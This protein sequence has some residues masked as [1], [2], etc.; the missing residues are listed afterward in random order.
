MFLASLFL[1]AGDPFHAGYSGANFAMQFAAV[2]SFSLFT[3]FLAAQS[4]FNF[5][6]LNNSKCYT[7]VKK[8]A[9]TCTFLLGFMITSEVVFTF[10]SN[11][12]A[13]A[14]F[15][16]CSLLML[17]LFIIKNEHLNERYK[18]I[19]LSFLC[20]NLLGIGMAG[21]TVLISYNLSL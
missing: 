17:V 5:Q 15:A 8:S 3:L 11:R 16:I 21:F 7:R 4:F 2:F 13:L 9:F 1:P 19:E 14:V 12:S 6:F 18:L 10:L 20:V